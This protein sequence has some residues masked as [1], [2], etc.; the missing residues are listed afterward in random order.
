MRLSRSADYVVLDGAFLIAE[1]LRREGRSITAN[2][3]KNPEAFVSDDAMEREVR[4]RLMNPRPCHRGCLT[5]AR[6]GSS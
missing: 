3:Y 6:Q 2:L 1:I 5:F 4:L